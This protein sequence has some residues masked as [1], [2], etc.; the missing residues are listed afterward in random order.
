MET[1]GN[2]SAQVE[3]AVVTTEW[4]PSERRTVISLINR[5]IVSLTAQ[6]DKAMYSGRISDISTVRMNRARITHLY[7]LIHFIST[8]NAVQLED[9]RKTLQGYVE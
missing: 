3:K 1:L 7:D 6:A 5:D 9:K 8:A 4:T 2:S